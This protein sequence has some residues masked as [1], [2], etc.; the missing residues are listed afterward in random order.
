MGQKVSTAAARV[1]SRAS[2]SARQTS[3]QHFSDPNAV[4]GG[5]ERG[6]GARRDIRDV[7]QQE[8][9]KQRAGGE[10]APQ[11]MPGDLIKF[12]SDVGPLKKRER[13]RDGKKLRTLRPQ[14]ATTV[15]AKDDPPASTTN[16]GRVK[17]SMPLA[18]KI[19]G[20]ETERTT[21]FSRRKD[22]FDPTEFGVDGVLGL[23]AL[24]ARQQSGSS[25]EDAANAVYNE[26]LA[27]RDVEIEIPA[28]EQE[29]TRQLLRDAT[30]HLELPAILQDTDRSYV[31]VSPSNMPDLKLLK[32]SE[33]PKTSVKLVLEDISDSPSS[34]S[35]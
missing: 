7:Q 2:K 9:L 32:L 12:L 26:W 3:K 31:G 27:G 22:V 15:E 23:Y 5:F 20:F 13:E 24:L 16:E 35:R 29:Q 4:H 1:S 33:V 34:G 10:Q 30:E 21:N 28:V 6:E 18:E 14:D 8:F 25:G 17:E 19:E 11:E